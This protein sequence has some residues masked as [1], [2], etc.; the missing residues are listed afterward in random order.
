M[1]ILRIA[2]IG[3][4]GVLLA[5]F[6]KQHKPEYSIFISLITG[7]IL[8]FYG[9]SRLETILAGIYQIE[10]R[11]PINLVY[12]KSLLKIIGVTYLAEFTGGICKEAGFG[13]IASQVEIFGK[14]AILAFGMPIITAL[15]ET[16]EQ[17]F[18]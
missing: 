5:L 16:V 7:V 17:F 2:M 13:V 8:F 14:L 6:L 1:D 18:G 10:M 15:L 3:I 9:I 4:C 12:M 11:L